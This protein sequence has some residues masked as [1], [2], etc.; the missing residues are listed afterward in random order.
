MPTEKQVIDFD[1]T[2]QVGSSL[3]DAGDDADA[4]SQA[5]RE[6]LADRDREDGASEE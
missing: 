5:V 2:G 1:P 4:G 6:V 3:P